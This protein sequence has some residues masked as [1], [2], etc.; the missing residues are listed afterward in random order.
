[1][2]DNERGLSAASPANDGL[3]ISRAE[4]CRLGVMAECCE[5]MAKQIQSWL[6]RR[7]FPYEDAPTAE[8]LVK[9]ATGHV[10][11]A[12]AIFTRVEN[13][14]PVTE[15]LKMLERWCADAMARGCPHADD[16]ETAFRQCMRRIQLQ[17]EGIEQEMGCREVPH[18]CPR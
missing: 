8:H 1:M 17:R 2:S 6:D 18:L 14:A 9:R 15:R 3:V 10:E 12:T 13:A 11:K 7:V 5:A 4:Y 16:A